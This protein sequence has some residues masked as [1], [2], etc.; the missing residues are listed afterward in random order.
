ME[1]T[2]STNTVRQLIVF[3]ALV[4]I[5]WFRWPQFGC[6]GSGC[7]GSSEERGG[8]E[9]HL[10]RGVVHYRPVSEAT[11]VSGADA[12]IIGTIES[13]SQSSWNQDDGRMWTRL[14][15]L[16]T[17]SPGATLAP[18]PFMYF[19]VEI[20]V[21]R[22][23]RDRLPLR[24]SVIVTLIGTSP[25]DQSPL[26]ASVIQEGKTVIAF[27][28]PGMIGWRETNRKSRLLLSGSYQGI[29]EIRNDGTLRVASEYDQGPYLRSKTLASLLQGIDSIVPL[30]RHDGRDK[31]NTAPS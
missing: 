16:E 31:A 5:I 19:D 18:V 28:A 9:R 29:Y 17:P 6:I 1:V 11:V 8:Q 30:S 24:E 10:P 3:V 27:V 7:A 2:Q 21:L 13:I 12:I 20:R 23:V 22:V 25:A 15:R 14:P 4:G 26:V